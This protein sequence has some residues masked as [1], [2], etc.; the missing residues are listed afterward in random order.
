MYFETKF[1]A[2][3]LVWANIFTLPSLT[4]FNTYLRSFQ[5]KHLHNIL[6]LNKNLYLCGITKIPLCSYCNI[7]NKTPIHLFCGCNSTKYSW[8]RLKQALSF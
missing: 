1:N 6:L 2:N 8:L 5:Y 7:I 3:N 4:T